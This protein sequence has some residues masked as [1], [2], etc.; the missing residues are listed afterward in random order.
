MKLRCTHKKLLKAL[1]ITLLAFALSCIL[2]SPLTFSAAQMISTPPERNDF[3]INDFYNHVADSRHVRTLDK[4]IVIID[5]GDCGREEI[6]NILDIVSLCSPRAVGLDVVF[7]TPRED[8]SHL[9]QDVAS[10]PNLILAESVGS[11]D[12][13]KS[14]KVDRQT[15]FADSLKDAS[16]GAINFPTTRRDATIREFRV[17]YPDGTSDIPSFALA[18]TRIADPFAAEKLMLRGNREEV[19]NFCSRTYLTMQPEELADRAPELEDKIILLGSLSGQEDLHVTPV[20]SAMTGVTIHAHA[21]STI[22]NESYFYKLNKYWN[23]VIAFLFCYMVIAISQFIPS[24]VKGVVMRIFQIFILY[25]TIRYGYDLFI[26]HSLIVNFSYSLLMITFGLL[27][28]DFWTGIENLVALAIPKLKAF[29]IPKL[30]I[31]N[32]R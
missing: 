28:S 22:I 19:I 17:S 16:F 6:A 15:F 9:I 29:S 13:G 30:K 26:R 12:A 23:W 7:E 25:L 24:G 32:P 5:I 8:D 10:C 20:K 1:G 18:V 21:I 11:D 31:F 3:T 2:L 14:F 27:A 4:D